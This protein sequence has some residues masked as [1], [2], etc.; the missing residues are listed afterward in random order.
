MDCL[1]ESVNASPRQV[2]IVSKK[3]LLR[4]NHILHLLYDQRRSYVANHNKYNELQ[5]ANKEVKKNLMP[6]RL[7]ND[8][9]ERT[10]I[11]SLQRKRAI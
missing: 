9:L 10:R 11:N 2:N 3:T 6:R 1:M 5:K 8:F 4:M 7:T